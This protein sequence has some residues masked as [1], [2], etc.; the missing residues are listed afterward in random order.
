MIESNEQSGCDQINEWPL[1][2]D[3]EFETNKVSIGYTDHWMKWNDV[4]CVDPMLNL[5]FLV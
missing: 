4:K 1:N 3:K 5:L 2:E